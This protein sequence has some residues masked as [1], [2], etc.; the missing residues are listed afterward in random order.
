ML[1]H[2]AATMDKY[3]SKGKLFVAKSHR[4]QRYDV[5]TTSSFRW[6]ALPMSAETSEQ[7]PQKLV[8]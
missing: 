8:G 4:V 6:V 5:I 7:D 1:Q 2:N 3:L